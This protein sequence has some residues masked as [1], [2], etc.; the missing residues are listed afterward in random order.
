MT[1]ETLPPTTELPI[2]ET[3]LP[4][5][6][7]SDDPAKIAAFLNNR[8]KPADINA[9]GDAKSQPRAYD[10][11][12]FVAAMTMTDFDDVYQIRA[13]LESQAH[14]LG[15]AFNYLMLEGDWKNLK[16]IIRT[17]K[18]MRDTI[19]LMNHY[20][21]LTHLKIPNAVFEKNMEK[22]KDAAMD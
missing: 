18:M 14:L 8:K 5:M 9:E 17:Q 19:E 22:K 11:A 20:P 3:S 12:D 7:L 2:P 4:L 6:F 16:N 10:F 13:T 1:E 21:P 15:T